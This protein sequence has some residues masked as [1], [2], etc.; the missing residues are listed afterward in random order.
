VLEAV[1]RG[2]DPDRPSALEMKLGT[3]EQVT[4]RV[5]LRGRKQPVE[6][7]RTTRIALV[8]DDL[9]YTTGGMARELLDLPAKVTFAVLPGL[10]ASRAFAESA[11][12]RGH[13]V[14]LHLPLEPR[15][16]AHHDPGHDA[17]F[18]DLGPEENRR[19]LADLLDGLPAYTG[20]S[21]HMGSRF[22]SDSGSVAW[23]LGEVRRRDRS[24][25]FLDSKTTPYSVIPD[26]AREVGVPCLSN[27]LF[28]D[29]VDP[30]LVQPAVQTRRLRRIA[31][32]RGQAI[33][34]GHVR[35]ETVDAVRA[36]IPHWEAEGIRLVGLSDLMHPGP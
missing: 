19:R 24:L 31:D 18:V 7:S 10:R 4:H 26:R 13:E 17:L 3:D 16:L 21:N 15:D 34:I 23:L 32:R 20:I 35:R 9:G 6:A 30:D 28:L 33:G 8:F 12:A 2:P 22:S 25:F 29:G 36:A 1:E 27:N 14:I 11:S 5:P